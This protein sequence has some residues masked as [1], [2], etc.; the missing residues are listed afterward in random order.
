MRVFAAPITDKVYFAL[1]SLLGFAWFVHS[2]KTTWP[3]IMLM[4]AFYFLHNAVMAKGKTYISNFA[5]P[6]LMLGALMT[7]HGFASHFP[8]LLA[9]TANSYHSSWGGLV[10][11]ANMC[12]NMVAVY[13]M[14]RLARRFRE[15]KSWIF[16]E[17]FSLGANF[18]MIMLFMYGRYQFD[19]SN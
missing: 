15:E 5:M 8:N 12:I 18:L 14:F 19:G 16:Y 1:F 11:G 7:F 3:V 17:G 9:F 10:A 13:V 6:F 2:L 4:A